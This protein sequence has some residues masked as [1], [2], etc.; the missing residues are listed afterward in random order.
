MSAWEGELKSYIK[1]IRPKF[2]SMLA[3]LVE[4]PSV[5]S[6]PSCTADIRCT[7]NLAAQF[8]RHLG[9]EASVVETEGY[10][11]VT[12]GWNVGTGLP[13]VTIYNHLDVQPALE[14]EWRP[15]PF[16]FK[17]EGNRYRGR[18]T[19]DDKGSALTALLAG[20]FAAQNG[21]P[22]NIRF[23]WELEEEIGSPHFNQVLSKTCQVPRSDSV[24]VSDTIWAARNRPAIPCGLRG[25]VS[26]TL[27]LQTGTTDVHSGLTGGGARNPLSELCEV[28][29]VCVHART[30]KVKIPGF[31]HDVVSPSSHEMKEYLSSGFEV[32]QFKRAF[33][34][35]SLRTEKR[36]EL[37][38]RILA[39]PTFEVHG[40]V[41]GHIGSGVKTVV[42]PRGELKVS[43]RLVPKQTPEKIF[44]LFKK[45]LNERFPDIR[46][47]CDG[48]LEPFQGVTK[49]PYADA[50]RRAVQVGFGKEPSLVRE[51]G[52]IGAISLLQRKW[53]VPILFMGLSLPEHGYHAPNEFFDWGQ[54]SVGMR[55][56]AH[57]FSELSQL[58]R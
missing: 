40:L 15:S 44:R 17:R 18:G 28:V 48:K 23:L 36:A 38:R 9:A 46:V 22:L 30:G 4:L 5:S 53:N 12:G 19:T 45:F 3:E 41:G 56:L 51:G 34:F 37:I 10:P 32:N 55:A 20:H 52:S 42:P 39:E 33:Q 43:M 50:I 47:D 25:L 11:A 29:Y 14:P 6:D 57:Y 7:A 49:G 31:Y 26:A 58:R 2:E 13:S 1:S 27:T 16:I 35:R 21:L 54:A 8:L 24:L